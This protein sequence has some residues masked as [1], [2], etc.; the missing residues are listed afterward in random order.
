MYKGILGFSFLL[1]FPLLRKIGLWFWNILQLRFSIRTFQYFKEIFWFF[2]LPFSSLFL[3]TRIKVNVSNVCKALTI[4]SVALGS[5]I[6]SW[7]KRESWVSMYQVNLVDSFHSAYEKTYRTAC[8]AF[9]GTRIC[10]A[11][12]MWI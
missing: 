11:G 1:Y 5:V 3:K 9:N 2:I 4:L 12:K 6:L 10:A 7:Q 8:A